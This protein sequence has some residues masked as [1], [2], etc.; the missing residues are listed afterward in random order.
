MVDSAKATSEMIIFSSRASS[1]VTFVHLSAR[2]PVQYNDH[3]SS[4]VRRLPTLLQGDLLPIS[5]P[6]RNEI[7]SEPGAPLAPTHSLKPIHKPLLLY[8]SHHGLLLL[9]NC[10]LPRS[11][12][13]RFRIP[14]FCSPKRGFHPSEWPGCSNPEVRR[15]SLDQQDW[16]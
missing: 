1:V 12:P 2:T 13:L 7:S 15:D 14:P 4:I 16:V 11:H 8:D 9:L 3:H 5:S 6:F 10:C